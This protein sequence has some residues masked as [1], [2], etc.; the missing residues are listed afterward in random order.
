MASGLFTFAQLARA[1]GMSIG[2]LRFYRECGL[3]Q[4]M[5]RRPGQRGQEKAFF[6]EHV[7]RLKFIKRALVCGYTHEDIA[8]LVDPVAMVTCRDV[9]T[10]TTHR[11]EDVRRSGR[12]DTP[13]ASF[14]A[15]LSDACSRVGSRGDCSILKSLST[16]GAPA[17]LTLRAGGSRTNGVVLHR[18]QCKPKSAGPS[19]HLNDADVDNA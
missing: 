4:P 7:E 18:R 16:P 19:E 14:L 3:L 17:S 1:V 9:Y 12:G 6:A 2:D 11:L 8:R 10:I 15:S 13:A 5:R